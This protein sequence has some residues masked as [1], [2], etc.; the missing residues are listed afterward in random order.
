MRCQAE[1]HGDDDPADGVV[2]DRSRDNDLSDIAPH[3][4]H[5]ADDDGDDFDGRDRQRGAEEQRCHQTRFR[6][7]Q[8]ALRQKF[9][10]RKAADEGHDN[11]GNRYRRRGAAD[12]RTSLRSVSMPVSSNSSRMPNCAMPSIRAF[13]S[14]DGGKIAA[15][16]EGHSQPNREGP[17]SSPP[18]NSPITEGWPIRCISSPSPRPTAI[19]S[20]IWARRMNSD[21]RAAFSPSASAA[22]TISRSASPAQNSDWSN[23]HRMRR[24]PHE[25][26]VNDQ[27]VWKVPQAFQPNVGRPAP[28]NWSP[29]VWSCRRG[30]RPARFGLAACRMIGQHVP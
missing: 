21:G 6:M 13:C 22:V 8:Q 25:F 3:E 2:D 1:D 20:A 30:E 16:A 28:P 10:E 17:S 12:F 9:A 24:F 19:R 4:I 29:P 27:E 18:S 23:L 15:W 5:F 7:R 26:P 14:P 11:A